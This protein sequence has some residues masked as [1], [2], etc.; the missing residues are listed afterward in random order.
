MGGEG[1]DDAFAIA[2]D[3]NKNAYVTGQ[4]FSTKFPTLNPLSDVPTLTSGPHVFVSSLNSAGTALNYSTYLGGN[5]SEAGDGLAVD[6]NGTAYVTG[7]TSS[8]NF[9]VTTSTFAGGNSSSFDTDAFVS[10]LSLN[11]ASLSLPFSTYLGGSGDEDFVFGA[12]AVTTPGNIYVTG[13]TNS[14]NFPVTAGAADSTYNGGS[15]ATCTLAGGGS[16]IPCP[17]AFVVAYANADFSIAG[18]A[19]AAVTAGSGST[20]TIT[21]TPFNG[22]SN[23]VNLSC[24]VSGGGTPAPTCQ[25][26]SNSISGGS[27][28]STLTVATTAAVAGTPALK[29]HG[30]LSVIWLPVGMVLAGGGLLGAGRQR[31]KLI[32]SMLV[33][34]LLAGTILLLSC[35]GSSSTAG[36]GP[37]ACSAAP[38]VPS[39][40]AASGTTTTGT[41]LNWTAD[42]APSDC[43]IA[44]Y[45]V[46]ENGTS[47]GTPTTTSFAVTGLS[48]STTYSFTI[49]ATDTFGSSAQSTAASVTT[50]S[51]GTP[52]GTYTITVTGTDGTITHSITPALTLTVN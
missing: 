2:V 27:G 12:V 50:G 24:S 51:S 6:S 38:G 16:P 15:A 14:A 48:P 18:T 34:A 13:V 35:G 40:L 37:V 3:S 44:S 31:K 5:G 36:S 8:T 19:L 49:A 23:T 22:Y 45:T 21:V 29:M 32:G 47:I 25:F 42:T 28:T 1:K 9:P 20:S 46:Y 26:S 17:D 7:Y 52:S 43:S 33:C 30:S 39:G 11:G 41:T 4:T 10:E